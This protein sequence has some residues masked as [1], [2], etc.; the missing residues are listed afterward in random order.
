MET[1]RDELYHHGVK[2][3]KWGVRRK[4]KY[5]A[6]N[7]ARNRAMAKDD[8]AFDKGAKSGKYSYQEAGRRSDNAASYHMTKASAQKNRAKA[9]FYKERAGMQ[10]KQKH[11]E[12]DLRKAERLEKR[13]ARKE[14]SAREIDKMARETNKTYDTKLKSGEKIATDLLM[15]T[16]SKNAY[17]QQRKNMS[18]KEAMGRQAVDAAL[19][20]AQSRGI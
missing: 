18:G 17:L 12:Q 2:G 1:Y 13:A 3:M 4:E 10:K 14:A 11:A 9:E 7:K 15:S 5:S 8:I 19:R 20:Y 6:I 16:D